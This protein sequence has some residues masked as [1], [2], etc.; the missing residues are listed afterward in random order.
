MLE[1]TVVSLAEGNVCLAF[2]AFVTPHMV[3]LQSCSVTVDLSSWL[4]QAHTRAQSNLVSFI[5]LKVLLHLP[6][7]VF[8]SLPEQEGRITRGDTL[9]VVMCLSFPE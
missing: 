7:G 5:T 4:T 9:P 3:C 8:G 6:I 2:A 1:E